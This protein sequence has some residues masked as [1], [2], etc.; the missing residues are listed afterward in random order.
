MRRTYPQLN[1]RRSVA[2]ILATLLLSVLLV[3]SLSVSVSAAESGTCGDGLTWS[4]SAGTLTI[5]GKGTMTQFNELDMPPWYELREQIYR[6]V[7]ADGVRSIAPLA[8]YDCQKITS[9]Y[10]PDSVTK[11]G[12]YAFANCERLE[13]VRFGPALAVIDAAAF[14][15]CYKLA[16]VTLP[17]SLQSLGNQAFYRCESL[18]TVTIPAFL[19]SMGTSVFAYCKSLVRAEVSARL[20]SMPEWTFYGCGKLTVVILPDTVGELESYAFKKCDRLDTVYFDGD[21][22]KT[23]EIREDLVKDVPIFEQVGTVSSALPMT[24]TTAGVFTEHG[25]GTVTQ[26]NTTVKSDGNMTF[27]SVIEHTY[28]EGGP[29][30]GG[31]YTADLTVTV[32][33]K[34]AWSGVTDTVKD[35]LKEMND[36]CA[37][38]GAASEGIGLTVYVQTE[39]GVD[40]SLVE[41]LAGRDVKMTVVSQN[42]SESR[43]EC[44]DLV[45][46]E[47]GGVY[48]YSHVVE[49]A[50]AEKMEALGTEDCFKVTFNESASV[51][52]EI[53]VQLPEVPA[54]SNAYLYQVE[55]DD[56]LTRLQATV[57]D[58][59]GNAHFYLGAVDKDTEYVV[60][61][62][63]PGENADDAII[64]DE[65]LPHYGDA[66]ERLQKIDYVITGRESSWGLNAAQVTWIML[67]VLAVCIIAVGTVMAVWNHNRLKRGY[68]PNL[69]DYEEAEAET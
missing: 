27:V 32:E 19:N 41:A 51:N 15:S 44:E 17:H 13:F 20:A 28:K 4:L 58:D 55:K 62:N 6:V 67:G 59:N 54:Y 33:N 29:A 56:T 60:G 36:S 69:E 57:V 38:G 63:V 49:E 45:I 43:M 21:S 42:G 22:E 64:P 5:S 31:T 11:I 30:V 2:F 52:S 18:A 65:L 47:L 68:V 24:S 61:V 37:Q 26:Q 8:F 7:I 48:D 23:Q 16:A 39:G 14:H 3:P 53:L 12:S 34:D 10:L 1:I 35:T 66:V 40:P 25:D 50:P 9:V 46:E